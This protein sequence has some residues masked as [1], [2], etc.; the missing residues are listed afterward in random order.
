[1]ARPTALTLALLLGIAAP[2]IPVNKAM[3]DKAILTLA[4]G[5]IDDFVKNETPTIILYHA[6]GDKKAGAYRNVVDEFCLER[7]A[8]LRCGAFD[9]DKD[10]D[11]ALIRGVII[12][13]PHIVYYG[14][15]GKAKTRLS[16]SNTKEKI[17]EFTDK[18]YKIE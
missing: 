2:A 12:G 4:K 3:G 17:A 16:G 6:R 7:K 14:S 10:S 5:D 8:S 11:D 15:D 18:V 1:M 13:T 9:V